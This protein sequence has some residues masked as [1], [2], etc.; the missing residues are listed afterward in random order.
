ME[1]QTITSANQEI[2]NR[3]ATRQHF[4]KNIELLIVLKLITRIIENPDGMTLS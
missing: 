1:K 2:A 4:R 3:L